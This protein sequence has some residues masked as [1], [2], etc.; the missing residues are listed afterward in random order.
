MSLSWRQKTSVICMKGTQSMELNKETALRLWCKSFGNVTKAEDFAGRTIAKGAYNDRN[1]NFG[2]N[3]DHILPQSEGG[4]TAEYNLICCHIKTNDEKA[5]SFPCFKANERNFEIIKVQNHYEIHNKSKKSKLNLYDSAS[6]IRYFKSL[7]DKEKNASSNQDRFIATVRIP[8]YGIK[9][10]AIL[11]FIQKIFQSY[12]FSTKPVNN[13]PPYTNNM[14]IEIRA[15][16]LP[17]KSDFQTLLDNCRLLYTYLSS[18]FVD[19]KEIQ[20]YDIYLYAD[21]IENREILYKDSIFSHTRSLP[22]SNSMYINH[23]IIINTDAQNYLPTVK[24]YNCPL[25][26]GNSYIKYNQPYQQLKE[27]LEKEVNG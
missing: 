17:N 4:K 13:W 27:G 5:D 19:T 3:V 22:F 21:H 18:Y 15:F 11:Y 20:G 24:D 16:D 23:L 25:I 9:S 10:N 6:G 1:S 26:L 2:W 8:L 7:V 12:E 14:E